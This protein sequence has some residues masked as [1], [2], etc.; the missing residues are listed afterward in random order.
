[1]KYLELFLF[2]SFVVILIGKIKNFFLKIFIFIIGASLGILDLLAIFTK[3]THIDMAF[4]SNI[5]KKSIKIAF[6]SFPI[7]SFLTVLFFISLILYIIFLDEKVR[8]KINLNKK[9][10]NIILSSLLILNLF[11]PSSI[12]RNFF[13][14]GKTLYS[15]TQ[16]K[17]LNSILKDLNIEPEDYKTIDK[18]EAT[19]GKNIVIIYLESIEK[20]FLDREIFK[21][22]T[23]NLTF[24]SEDKKNWTFTDKYIQTPGTGW[25]MGGI[26]S[27]QTG[28]PM[29]FGLSGN[30][31]LNNIAEL[32]LPSLGKILQKAGYE[33]RF[34]KGFDLEFSGAGNFFKMT[35]Y[36][37][38]GNKELDPTYFRSVWGV[39]D[40]DIFYEA[41]KQ[42]SELSSTGKPFNLTLLTVDTHFPNG[43][44]DI[45]FTE[46]IDESFN[47]MQWSAYAADYLLKDFI[48]FINLQPNA[49]NTVVYILPDHLMMGTPEVTPIVKDLEKKERSLWLLSNATN[50]NLEE[51]E[52]IT[53]Y[54]I[55]RLILNGA[56]I[57]C[58]VKFIPE[59]SSSFDP[60]DENFL[61]ALQSL[62]L[63]MA[64]FNT[65]K[66][67]IEVKREGIELVTFL[68]DLEF[69]R[70]QLV[71]GLKRYYP[72][73]TDLNIKGKFTIDNYSDKHLEDYSNTP[74]KLEI[75]LDNQNQIVW[76]VGNNL[77]LLF[78]KKENSFERILGFGKYSLNKK[79]ET[80]V[81]TKTDLKIKNL[82]YFNLNPTV[83]N[84]YMIASL[85]NI[86]NLNE[87]FSKLKEIN[88]NNILILISIQDEGT[89]QF[90]HFKESFKNFSLMDLSDKF[91]HSY[92][93]IF[94]S[95]GKIYN[96]ALN[97]LRVE[98]SIPFGKNSIEVI[99]AGFESGNISSIR[100]NGTE[101]SKNRRGLN[102]VVFDTETSEVVDSFNVDTYE[103][104]ELKII[105]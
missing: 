64:K 71:K 52:L 10:S 49:D 30:E 46:M 19:P 90:I 103:D 43:I 104:S 97:N 96:E 18:I 53:F 25:T 91:R 35:G 15:S 102:I 93:A 44:K 68:D 42:F 62:N 88:K 39:R 29:L 98:K 11:L 92:L 76:N 99:S 70:F 13:T 80:P 77:D 5:D 100:I 95:D 83:K 3:S 84:Y 58:N 20:G 12:V 47:P 45:R 24:F 7:Y 22:L 73:D 9:F 59:L 34:I 60:N 66:E 79:V 94:T 38:F 36:S 82:N 105:R 21:N 85:K 87:Y 81:L 32:K 50:L 16:K 78:S 41:K 31:I 2:F 89:S 6:T 37:P 40:K 69:D 56:E 4:I 17:D 55:P 54:D 101:Y 51:K 72:I 74:F 14:L 27:T 65:I 26:Y 28:M 61:T 33:Q 67:K 8:K 63:N 75:Y 48:D 23:P 1:M 57:K 86:N